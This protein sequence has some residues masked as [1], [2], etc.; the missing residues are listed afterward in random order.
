M[1]SPLQISPK[2]DNISPSNGGSKGQDTERRLTTLET[3]INY[4]A[5]KEDIQLVKTEIEKTRTE[6]EKTRT[7]IEK[8]KLEVW[9]IILLAASVAATIG[10]AMVGILNLF[11]K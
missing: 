8:S 6:I 2:G 9:K 7:E 1:S 10:A 4:L 5:T 3:H 11:I